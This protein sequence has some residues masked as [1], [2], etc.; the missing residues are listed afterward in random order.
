MLPERILMQQ[1]VLIRK[2]SMFAI[3]LLLPLLATQCGAED[4]SGFEAEL[5]PAELRWVTYDTTSQVETLLVEKFRAEHPEITFERLQ[6]QWGHDYFSDTPLPDLMT[7]SISNDYAHAIRNGQLADLSE[8]WVEAA[9]EEKLLGPVQKLTQDANSGKQFM[10][11]V[12]FSWAGIYYNKG[13]FAQYGLQPPQTWDEF[14][15]LCATLKANGETPLVMTGANSYSFMLW[16][17]YLNLRINGADYHRDLLTGRERY[18]D[19]RI[20]N[21]LDQWRTL[22]DQ[23]FTV[24]RPQSFGDLAAVSALIRGDNGMLHGEEAVM[25]LMDAYSITQTPAKFREEFD[26][27]RFPIIDPSVPLVE[28]MGVAGYIIPAGAD[29]GVQALNFLLYLSSPESQELLAIEELFDSASFAPAR[30][31]LDEGA[32]SDEMSKATTL[33]QEAQDVVPFTFQWMPNEM[34]AGFDIG[35]RRFLNPEHDPQRFIEALEE[36]R[37]QAVNNG[38]FEQ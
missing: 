14:L 26:F 15:Q 22:F 32:L 23:E 7:Y 36:A 8:L 4:D 34:W 19:P 17:D 1:R 25:L 31:D 10:L 11:P 16:F 27:F 37:Q 29:H 28:P 6:Y 35:Y 3:L 9:L 2:L 18:D 38:S 12:A 20:Y 33:I 5:E 24:E 21:V 30:A 13:V